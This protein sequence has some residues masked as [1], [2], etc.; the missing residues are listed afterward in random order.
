MDRQYPVL[1]TGLVDSRYRQ[2]L[3]TLPVQAHTRQ[4]PCKEYLLKKQNN[5]DNNNWGTAVEF[6][7]LP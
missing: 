3:F 6:T 2:Y 7:L 4:L 1:V 5:E